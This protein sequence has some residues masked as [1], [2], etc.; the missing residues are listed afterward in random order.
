M[1]YYRTVKGKPQ[2]VQFIGTVQ[3]AYRAQDVM[4]EG[5]F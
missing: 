4:K 1:Q 5:V 2:I 3:W